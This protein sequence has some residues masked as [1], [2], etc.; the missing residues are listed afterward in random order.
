FALDGL[1]NADLL[2]VEG[3]LPEAICRFKHALIQD[4]AYDSLLRGRRQVL[5]G[6]TAKALIESSGEPEAVAYHCREAGLDDLAIEWWGKAGEDA[7]RR[8]AYKEA[9]AH[10]GKAIAMADT[11]ESAATHQGAGVSGVSS[12][13]LKLHTDYGHAAMW[14]KGFAADEMSDAYK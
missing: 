9:I 10:L 4:A 11:A 13:L 1:V 14:L 2:F 6:R 12:R 5:H 7:L 3:V 8:S